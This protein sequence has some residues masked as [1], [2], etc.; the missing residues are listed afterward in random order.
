MLFENTIVFGFY[1]TCKHF[2]RLFFK[3]AK[4]PS[5]LILMFLSGLTPMSWP[6]VTAICNYMD[7]KTT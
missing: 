6:S 7:F 5:L 2:P 3:K 4:L 1:L